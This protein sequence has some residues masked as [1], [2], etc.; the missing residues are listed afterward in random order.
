MDLNGTQLL[1]IR[2]DSMKTQ[3]AFC[4][5]IITILSLILSFLAIS[6]QIP[7]SLTAIIGTT[8]CHELT[9]ID[10]SGKFCSTIHFSDSYLWTSDFMNITEYNQFLLVRARPIKRLSQS[11]HSLEKFDLKYSLKVDHLDNDGKYSSVAW[12]NKSHTTIVECDTIHKDSKDINYACSAF[13]IF[14]E[15]ELLSGNYKVEVFFENID[16]IDHI[17][18]GIYFD[19]YRINDE[20]TG[21]LISFRYLAFT[22]S[23]VLSVCYCVNFSSTPKKMRVFEQK[24]IVVL[25]VGLNLFNDPFVG[26]NIVSPSNFRYLII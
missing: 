20:Y 7:Q 8:N 1:T 3:T 6:N 17:V 25:G 11:G 5:Y 4:C 10:K 16:E 12:S 24:Y 19:A 21:F 18:S 13:N 2:G 9:D 26:I 23:L 15:P 22:I 14:L